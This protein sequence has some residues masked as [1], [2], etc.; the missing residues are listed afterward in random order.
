MPALT[1]RKQSMS[2]ARIGNDLEM[3]IKN[4]QLQGQDT[5][6]IALLEQLLS[7]IR[8]FE[9]VQTNWLVNSGMIAKYEKYEK[10]KED[11]SKDKDKD[12]SKDEK[13]DQGKDKDKDKDKDK[14]KD[15]KETQQIVLSQSELNQEAA[16]SLLQS[17]QLTS[18]MAKVIIAQIDPDDE[19]AIKPV[20]PKNKSITILDK[21]E[22]DY[23][24]LKKNHG[25]LLEDIIIC[26]K[27]VK[28][29]AES[30][31]ETDIRKILS[32]PVY[33]RAHQLNAV[34]FPSFQGLD[35]ILGSSRD[36]TE[37]KIEEWEGTCAGH[38]KS[39][40]KIVSKKEKYLHLPRMDTTTLQYQNEENFHILSRKI[41]CKNDDSFSTIYTK[42]ETLLSRTTSQFIYYFSLNTF[43]IG[44][45]MSFRKLSLGKIEFFDPNYG[46]FVFNN[47]KSFLAWTCEL[48]KYYMNSMKEKDYFFYEMEIA[49]QHKNAQPT[50]PL[51]GSEKR[52]WKK[53]KKIHDCLKEVLNDPIWNERGEN[54]I[55]TKIPDGIKKCM[56]IINMPK[57]SYE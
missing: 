35:P 53:T 52:N 26:A 36:V 41:E 44:H 22:A 32:R 27:E 56:D 25:K 19:D 17:A 10:D 46:V 29:H 6:E 15:K 24:Y 12:K 28:K 3:K 37:D 49:L 54:L 42:M 23:A 33:K 30:I 57:I 13:K 31:S 38:V 11:K 55:G 40:G 4:M 5:R 45:A 2:F 51:K 34:Y 16:E 8:A 9:E 50:I 7:D 43:N 21:K 48:L 39:Y 20:L 18:H 1:Q 47:E 14:R